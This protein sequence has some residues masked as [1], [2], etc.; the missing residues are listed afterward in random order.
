MHRRTKRLVVGLAAGLA[1]LAVSVTP[2]AAQVPACGLR[3]SIVDHL[4]ARYREV[5]QAI[6]LVSEKAIMEVYA[7]PAG[8]WTI[9]MSNPAG[10]S[11]IIASGQAWSAHREPR[12]PKI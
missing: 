11:C 6:G 9:L 1:L 4:S 8:S 7:S 2:G 10:R 3:K 12:G 5:R